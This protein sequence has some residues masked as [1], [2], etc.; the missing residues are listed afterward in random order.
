MI[1]FEKEPTLFL[2]FLNEQ[3]T[4]VPSKSNLESKSPLK[5][6][7]DKVKGPKKHYT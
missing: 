3:I 2:K 7:G 6:I 1:V 4:K 5:Q